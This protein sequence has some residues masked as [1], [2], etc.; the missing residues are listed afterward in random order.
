MLKKNE[1]KVDKRSTKGRQKVDKK[2]DK[3]PTKGR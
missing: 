3:S 2:V 1:K